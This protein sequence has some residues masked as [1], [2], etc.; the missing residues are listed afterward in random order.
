SK[1]LIFE[2]VRGPG[3]KK[4][5]GK[6]IPVSKGIAGMVVKR[7][8]PYVSDDLKS[9]KAWLGRKGAYKGKN[10]IVAPIKEGTEVVAVLA[11][12]NKE[13]GECFTKND[14]KCLSSITQHLSIILERRGLFLELNKR[15]HQDKVLQEVGALLAST[16]DEKVVRT[17]AIEAITKLVNAN[18][19]SLLMVDD[20]KK[21]LFFEVALGVKGEM[22]KELR[23]KVGEGIAGWVAKYAKPL[24]INDARSDKRFQSKMDKKSKFNTR[25]LVCVPVML[26][27]KVIGVL[28]AIN[29]SEGNFNDEDASLLTL[30][31][32][33][34]AIALDNARLYSELREAFYA[35]SESLAEAI[36]K[37]DPYTGGHTKRVL[38]FS[39]AIGIEMALDTEAIDDLKLAA[40]LHDIGKIGI[41]DAILRKN[42][43]LNDEEFKSMSDHPRIGADIIEYVPKLSRIVPGI[44]YHHERVDGKGYPKKLKKNK[45]PLMARI[46]AVADTYDAMTT[47]RPYRK[48]LSEKVAIKELRDC[49]GT[50]FDGEVVKA[51]IKA[52]KKGIIREY[53]SMNSIVELVGL[54]GSH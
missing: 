53:S 47:T 19:G 10:M 14:L 20:E 46:I 32:N 4:L 39:L 21:E 8:K 11:L 7:C 40:I 50:Q 45:I 5:Q 28:Q 43:R 24:V 54:G 16:L 44:Y 12:I 31:S 41:D 17:R 48:S 23:L 18:V 51:F 33:Q 13:G 27:G 26:K 15:L 36:E 37:R 2:V 6:R 29:K 22:V 52:Y 9:E 49:S 3:A 35:T 38:A 30:F 42:G 1:E 25:N 34:V